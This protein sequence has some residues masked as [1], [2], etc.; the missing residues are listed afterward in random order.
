MPRFSKFSLSRCI[1]HYTL[2][3]PLLSSIPATPSVRPNSALFFKNRATILSYQWN[4]Y[5][6]FCRCLERYSL[7]IHQNEKSFGENCGEK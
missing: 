1:P 4:V 5:V 2:C 3:V 7:Q 6:W